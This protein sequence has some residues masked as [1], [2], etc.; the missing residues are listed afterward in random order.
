[1]AGL[2]TKL[3]DL[4]SEFDQYKD[5]TSSLNSASAAQDERLEK[6]SGELTTVRNALVAARQKLES[7][8]ANYKT[9]LAEVKSG[10]AGSAGTIQQLKDR[11]LELN[12]E[13]TLQKNLLEQLKSRE[14][15]TDLDAT[16]DPAPP[17]ISQNKL[18]APLFRN[19]Q[20]KNGRVVEMAF[21]RR[22][23]SGEFIFIGR[24][25][26]LYSVPPGRLSPE[27]LKLVESAIN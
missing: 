17:V 16:V 9:Q 6:M 21:I 8:Q 23:A 2:K 7:Q 20:G 4:Q 10:H 1:M 22:D 5:S 15:Q 19:W 3:A 25:N 13:L 11:N 26:Q 27:D 24:D 14:V 18:P 12:A